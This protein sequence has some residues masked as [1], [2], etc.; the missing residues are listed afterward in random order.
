MGGGVGNRVSEDGLTTSGPRA[1]GPHPDCRKR[2]GGGEGVSPQPCPSK[3][4]AGLS[5]KADWCTRRGEKLPHGL[6]LGDRE[7]GAAVWGGGGMRFVAQGKTSEN[8]E[9]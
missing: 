9:S 5:N 3:E 4:T 1:A 2:G 7:W 6:A 8:R